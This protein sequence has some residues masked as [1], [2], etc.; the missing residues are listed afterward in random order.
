MADTESLSRKQLQASIYGLYNMVWKSLNSL[1]RKY[2]K[3]KK[4]RAMQR[5]AVNS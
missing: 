5:G 1:R 4:D 3:Y 2:I